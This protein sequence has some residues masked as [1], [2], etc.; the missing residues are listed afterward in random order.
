MLAR[1][2]E[3]QKRVHGPEHAGLGPMYHN[4]G[5]LY[6]DQKI[7]AEAL[8]TFKRALDTRARARTHA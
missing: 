2:L 7:Y 8:S 3:I 5:M 4:L 1:S 6:V